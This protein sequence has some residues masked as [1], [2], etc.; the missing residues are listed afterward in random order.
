MAKLADQHSVIVYPLSA[1]RLGAL[2][3]RGLVLGFAVFGEAEIEEA[4][5]KLAR[6]W[7]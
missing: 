5:Q 4:V 6:A 7:R 3:Q 2:S 1:F